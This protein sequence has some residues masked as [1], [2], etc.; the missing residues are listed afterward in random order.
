MLIR[1]T[2]GEMLG[3]QQVA[4]YACPRWLMGFSQA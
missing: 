1:L 2:A 4:A 3:A